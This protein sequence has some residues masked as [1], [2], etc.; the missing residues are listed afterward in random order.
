MLGAGALCLGASGALR[1]SVAVPAPAAP[2]PSDSGSPG[3]RSPAGA[4][5]GQG[6]R[7]PPLPDLS[8]GPGEP[9]RGR[10]RGE[11]PGLRVSRVSA[12]LPGARFHGELPGARAFGRQKKLG[13]PPSFPGPRT[14]HRPPAPCAPPGSS[15]RSSKPG[16]SPGPQ[17]PGRTALDAPGCAGGGRALVVNSREAHLGSAC[18]LQVFLLFHTQPCGVGTS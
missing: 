11:C 7:A 12:P 9:H 14:A 6:L 10:E 15:L 3:F 17:H 1:A 18:S 4:G 2:A 5:M 13:G 8:D 16:P